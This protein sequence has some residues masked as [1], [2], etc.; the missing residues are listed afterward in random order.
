MS[1]LRRVRAPSFYVIGAGKVGLALARLLRARGWHFLGIWNRGLPGRQRARRLLGVAADRG[2]L[3]EVLSQAQLVLVTVSDSAV[4]TIGARLAKVRYRRGAVVV[5]TSG[6]LPA[7][8][9]GAGIGAHLGSIHPVVA[10][11]SAAQAAASLPGAA[12]AIEGDAGA[13]V[14]LRRMAKALAGRAFVIPSAS[15]AHYHAALVMASNL[16]IALLHLALAEAAAAGLRSTRVGLELATH[17]LALAIR[18]GTLAALT[19]PIVR[20][21]AQTVAEHMAALGPAA[22]PAYIALSR[23]AL[24][25][26]QARGLPKAS[27]RR[28]AAV[29]K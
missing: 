10:C 18:Q 14:L 24:A 29:L 28:V 3:P 8:A 2:P 11:A 19:G 25:M 12:F 6:A 17:T 16:V 22:R 23:A 1:R 13:K 20:G 15:K 4:A 7:S 9:L 27:V 5:H 21:D 26:A